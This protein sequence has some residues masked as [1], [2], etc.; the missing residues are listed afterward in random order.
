MKSPEQILKE[1]C[2]ESYYL[3]P[4][5]FSKKDIIGFMEKY[6]DQFRNPPKKTIEDIVSTCRLDFQPIL[7]N[8]MGYKSEKNQ[9]Y[10]PI[11]LKNLVKKFNAF[12][13]TYSELE[14]LVESSM[15]NNYSGI[16]WT[17]KQPTHGRKS[18]DEAIGDLLS[19]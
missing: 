15:I 6:A 1:E 18:A 10:K 19:N 13:G 4:H 5:Q 12:T 7:K 8:W 16:I 2:G 17:N 9:R 14:S 3:F 11:G